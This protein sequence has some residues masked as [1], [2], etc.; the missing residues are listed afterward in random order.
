MCG[1][2]NA[3]NV[4][5]ALAVAVLPEYLH[6]SEIVGYEGIDGEEKSKEGG[7]EGTSWGREI[8]GKENRRKDQVGRFGSDRRISKL[9][10]GVGNYDFRPPEKEGT[11]TASWLQR[12]NKNNAISP[13]TLWD[14][15]L[16]A[17]KHASNGCFRVGVRVSGGVIAECCSCIGAT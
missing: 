17:T 8:E 10:A 3:S 1:S 2:P 16:F 6:Y 14:T 7:V 4:H 13:L 15:V 5:L 12:N 11:I 9:A